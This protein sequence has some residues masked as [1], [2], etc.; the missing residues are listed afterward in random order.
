MSKKLTAKE[1]I[2]VKKLVETQNNLISSF[3]RF[4]KQ[5]TEPQLRE[6][7]QKICASAKNHKRKL[8]KSLEV[9]DE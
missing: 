8:L 5:V 3:E 1:F 6:V 4:S 2:Q 7:F 9:P